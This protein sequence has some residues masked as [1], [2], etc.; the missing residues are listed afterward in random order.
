VSPTPVYTREEARALGILPPK[1][2]A[3]KPR[4]Q[5]EREMTIALAEWLRLM[6]TTGRLL[7]RWTHVANERR[8]R[9]EA[10]LA[11]RMG[12]EAGCPDLVFFLRDGR[13]AAIEM[14][15][16]GGKLSR[17]QKEWMRDLLALGWLWARCESIE[18]VEAHLVKWGALLPKRENKSA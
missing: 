4:E 7:A 11:H 18:E 16:P 5:S 13:G 12:V 1:P 17:E 2:A 6:R 14:K 9:V 3:A 10:I 8:D 15:I